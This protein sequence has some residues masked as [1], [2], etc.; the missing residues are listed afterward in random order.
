I[1]PE[2]AISSSL[3]SCGVMSSSNQLSSAMVPFRNS[4][5]SAGTV[6][7][8]AWFFHFQN[9]FIGIFLL[10][11]IVRLCICKSPGVSKREHIAVD[12]VEIAAILGRDA[13][14]ILQL[15]DVVG[16]HPA[17]LPCRSVAVH[18]AGIVATEQPLHIELGK[19]LFLFLC[20]KERPLDGLLPA[21]QP[22]RSEE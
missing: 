18:A 15:T 19:I 10:S 7:V 9:F 11:V 3:K 16:A 17:V 12:K 21:Y 4:V 5:R 22:G 20:G 1:T 2:P 6:S 13:V 14:H 8:A